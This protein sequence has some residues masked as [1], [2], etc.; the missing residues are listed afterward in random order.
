MKSK[1]SFKDRFLPL[2]PLLQLYPIAIGSVL[3]ASPIALVFYYMKELGILWIPV[4]C[5]YWIFLSLA[6]RQVLI[7]REMQEARF[8]IADDE[9]FFKVYPNFKRV[10]KHILFFKKLLKKLSFHK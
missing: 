6:V 2:V 9:L 4:L 8:I 5:V 10:E 7:Y 1:Q 3:L